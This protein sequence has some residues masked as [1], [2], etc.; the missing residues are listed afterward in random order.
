MRAGGAVL[1][2]ACGSG[3]HLRWLA[4]RG[5][6]L[7]GVDRDAAAVEPLRE[8]AEIVVADIENGPWPLE[9]R[10]FDGI[11]VTN[12]LWRALMPRIEASL[13]PG[14]VLIYETFAVGHELLGRPSNPDFLLRE[15]ELLAAFPAL[16]TVAFE[17][18][19]EAEPPRRVQRLVAVAPA[20][21]DAAAHAEGPSNPAA[22]IAAFESIRL[23]PP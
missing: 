1:D 22:K 9:G 2:L 8:A 6:R 3:R 20:T 16:R 5:W 18:G 19:F 12:Y 13:A 15:G 11:V 17:D 7:T 23:L 14:G 4:A 10:R 21:P